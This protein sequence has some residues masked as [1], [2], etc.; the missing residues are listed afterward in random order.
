MP[1]D[2]RVPSTAGVRIC[3]CDCGGEGPPLLFL[4]ANGFHGR[5]YAPMVRTKRCSEGARGGA[6]LCRSRVHCTFCTFLQTIHNYWSVN[7]C[8]LD[9]CKQGCQ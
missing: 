6:F 2:V 4:A 9:C 5:C 3:V 1:E 8:R 7:N